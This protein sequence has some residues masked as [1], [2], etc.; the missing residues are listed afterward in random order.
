MYFGHFLPLLLT[1]CLILAGN[2]HI[3]GQ[4]KYKSISQDTFNLTDPVV[5][6]NVQLHNHND[7]STGQGVF[8]HSGNSNDS[9]D[10][11]PFAAGVGIDSLFYYDSSNH[12]FSDTAVI[13]VNPTI[14]YDTVYAA[15]T[16]DGPFNIRHAD[17]S[18]KVVGSFDSK[19][20]AYYGPGISTGTGQFDPG[21]GLAAGTYTIYAADTVTIDGSPFTDLDSTKVNLHD[22]PDVYNLEEDTSFCEGGP[23]VRLWLD[24]NQDGVHYV[25]E[26]AGTATPLDT[27][28]GDGIDTLAFHELSKEGTYQ[29][30]AYYDSIGCQTP[31]NGTVTVSEITA[32]S[33]NLEYLT[34]S[35]FCPGG[36]GVELGIDGSNSNYSYSLY[37]TVS[38]IPALERTEPG[39][40]SPVSLGTYSD[41]AG[42]YAVEVS[43]GTC[44]HSLDDTLKIFKKNSPEAYDLSGPAG[45]CP[46]A[47]SVQFDLSDSETGM[48]YDLINQNTGV[49]QDSVYGTGSAIHFTV[50]DTGTY[51]AMGIDTTTGCTNN[52]NNTVALALYPDVTANAWP[53]TAI[54]EGASVDLF[55][56]GAGTGGSY[57]WNPD[58]SMTGANTDNPTASPLSTTNYEV[59]FTDA[60]GCEAR[61]TVTVTVNNLPTAD[62]GTDTSVCV[63]DSVQLAAGQVSGATYSWSPDG[64][65]SSPDK[66][67][68]YA[69]PG[70]QTTYT[71]TV[72]SA[73][74][75]S[76]TDDVV[77][78]ADSVPSPSVKDEYVCQGESVT[79]TAGGGDSYYWP[80]E[81]TSGNSISVSPAS[82]ESYVVEAYY[83]NGCSANDTARVTVHPTPTINT[84][85]TDTSVCAQEDVTIQSSASGGNTPYTYSWTPGGGSGDNK[86]FTATSDETYKVTVTDQNGC[87]DSAFVPVTVNALPTVSISGLDGSYCKDE[88][89]DLITGA[90]TGSGGAF[91]PASV[92]SD[93]GDGTADFDPSS[94]SPDTY[95]DIT[96]SFTNTHGCEDTAMATTYV[97]NDTIPEPT[98]SGLD[99]AYCDDDTGPY[100]IT[101]HP[102]G[103]SGSFSSLTG[104]T[105]NGD[106]TATLDPQILADNLG[107]GS[108]DITYTYTSISGGCEGS[109]TETFQVGV[110]FTFDI[111]SDYCANQD[112]FR[113]QVNKPTNAGTG[114]FYVFDSAGDT[115][116]SAKEG[117]SNAIFDPASQGAGDYGVEY[118]VSDTVLSCS[119]EDSTGFTVHPVP[120]ARFTLD[121]IVNDSVDIQFCNNYGV[122]DLQGI[123]NSGG[124]YYGPG[125]SG[126][127]LETDSTLPG[128]IVI[129]RTYTSAEGCMDSVT[130]DVRIKDVPE[131]EI[132]GL[133]LD[134]CNNTDMF[135][136]TADPDSG[137]YTVPAPLSDPSIFK[138]KGQGKADFNPS[139]AAPGTYN[140]QYTGF[141][142][143]G[144]S[145]D[146]TVDVTIQPVPNVSVTGLPG[147]GEV[148]MNDS[149]IGVTGN[150]TDANGRFI[151]PSFINDHSDGTA[152]LDPSQASSS[153]SY[154]VIYEYVNSTSGCMARDT[155]II[156]ILPLPQTYNL[157]GGGTFCAGEAGLQLKLTDSDSSMLYSL[158]K[159]GSF[160]AD[161]LREQDGNFTFDGY[162]QEGTYLVTAEHAN[163]CLDTMSNTATITVKHAPED[164]YSITGDTVVATTST[165]SY[166]HDALDYTDQYN[167]E[168]PSGAV[169]TSGS[170]TRNIDV[171]FS[172]V[173]PGYD[174][175]LVYGT[176]SNSCGIGDTA[177]FKVEIV[178]LPDT[179][180]SLT[181][182]TG[183]CEGA[184]NLVYSVDPVGNADS[185]G[186]TIPTGFQVTTGAGTNSIEVDLQ[187]SASSGWVTARGYNASGSGYPDSLYVTVN[188]IP[189]ITVNNLDSVYCS[190]QGSFTIT[191]TPSGGIYSTPWSDPGIF[192]DNGD[193][194][195]DFNP[196]QLAGGTSHTIGYS[197]TVNGCKADTTM[198][199]RINAIPDV[200][201]T[202][203]PDTLC[204]NAAP[205][206]LEGNHK[207]SYASFTGPGIN[208]NND[209]TAFFYP[210]SA[211]TGDKTITYHYVD[212]LTGC[213]NDTSQDIFIKPAPQAYT[214]L[215]DGT[216]CADTPGDSLSLGGAQAGHLY[217][218]IRNGTTVAYDTTVASGGGFTFDTTFTQGS[219]EV[220]ATASNGCPDTMQNE[221]TI[222][223]K[224]LPDGAHSV[225]GDDTVQVDG[226]G[227]YSVPPIA[228]TADYHWIG[229]IVDS[230]NGTR[231]VK[232]DFSGLSPGDQT[233]G[234][235]GS[236]GCGHG[237]TAYYD[238]YVLP[239]PA[240]LDS[241]SGDSIVCAGSEGLVYQ[242]H[243]TLSEVDSISWSV[244]AGFDI[245]SG[246]GT[247][248]I[249]VH[250]D[251]TGA[252]SGNI[253]AQGV[254]ASGWGP[255]ESLYVT[256][257]PIPTTNSVS[258]TDV[259]DCNVNSVLLIGNSSTPGATYTWNGGGKTVH[260][261]SIYAPAKGDYTLTVDAYGCTHDTTITVQENKTTPSISTATPD[262]LTCNQPQVTLE[263]SSDA[264]NPYYIWTAGSGGHIVSGDSTA[265]PT[266]DSSATYT[267]Q[268][269]DSLNGCTNTATVKVEEDFTK[270]S[271][272][273]NDPLDIT[274][275][276][277]TSVVST[278]GLADASYHWSGPAGVI[279][280]G[281]NTAS[282]VVDKVGTYSLKVTKDDNGCSYTKSRTVGSDSTR[283]TI[284]SYT[285]S[286]D[287][288][289]SEPSVSLDADVPTSNV[290]Y[291]FD[292]VTSGA[293]ESTSGH[294]AHVEKEDHYALTV[295]KNNNGCSVTDTVFVENKQHTVNV[296]IDVAFATITCNKPTDT[297]IVT[298]D[299]TD[300]KV[301]WNA[302]SGGH[303]LSGHLSKQIIVDS[304]GRY[305]ATVTDTLTGCSNSEYADISKDLS[306]PHI[307]PITKSPDSITCVSDVNLK[308]DVIGYAS[309][310]WTGPGTISP[311]D[312]D[313]VYVSVPGQYTLT[314]TGSNGCTSSRSEDV[315]A[316]TASPDMALTTSYD[317]ITCNNPEE[318][319]E[320]ASSTPNVT[321]QWSRIAGSG[322][323]DNPN[324]QY[325]RVDGPGTYEVV[326]TADNGCITSG[327]VSVDTSYAQPVVNGFDSNPDSISCED[328]WVELTASSST[329]GADLLWTTT[330]TGDILNETTDTALVDAKGTYTLTV[331]HPTTGCTVDSTVDVYNNFAKPDAVVDQNVGQFT[332][333]TD[334]LQLDGTASTGV[335]F[336]W[337]TDN[338]HILTSN[339]VQQPLIGSDGK[340]ILTVEHP[341]SGCTDQ[342]S[343]VVTSNNSVP[344]I[345]MGPVSTD[346]LNCAVDSSVI[347]ISSVSTTEYWWTTP[348]GHIRRGDSSLTAVVD[349]PGK[350]VFTARNTTTGCTNSKSYNIY[351]ETT[352]PRVDLSAEKLTC[353]RDTAQISSYLEYATDLS[354]VSWSWITA[355]GQIVTAKNIPNPKVVKA[356]TYTLTLTDDVNGCTR[357]KDIDV[358]E[359]TTAPVVFVDNNVNDIT[360]SRDEV[361]LLANTNASDSSYE[362]ST[363]GT[364]NIVNRYTATPAVDAPGWYTVEITD[365][366]NGCS[367]EDSVYVDEDKG[368]PDLFVDPVKDISCSRSS[369][370]L[371]AG[372]SD[373]VYYSWSGGPGNISA[374]GSS[375]T[376]VDAGG[377]Y[378]ITLEDKVTGCTND[379]TITVYE[380]TDAPSAPMV[381]DTG[382]CYGSAN[383]AIDASGSVPGS[384][385][386][387]YD[388]PA[389]GAANQIATGSSYTP[390]MSSV[391]DSVFYVTQTGANGCESPAASAIYSV[392]GLPDAPAATDKS[393]CFGQANPFLEAYPTDP[394]NP[395]NWYNTSDSLL[396]TSD[397]YQPDPTT[398]GT[399]EY[400]V[401]QVD[402]RGCESP[403]EQAYFTIYDL[404]AAPVVDEDTL[405]ICEGAPDKTFV[406]HGTNVKWYNTMPPASEIAT[407]N[408]FTPG[409]S[410][411]GTYTFYVTQS[412]SS[413]GC[414]SYYTQVTY[415]I[416]AN[417]DPYAVQGGGTYCEG[418]GGKEIFLGNSN[419]TVSYELRQD[420]NTYLTNISG[421][422]DSLSFGHI[423]PEGTYT[424]YGTATNG[425]T[426]K[427]TGTAVI[428]VDSLP[429][430]AGTITGD[431]VLCQGATGVDYSVPEISYA[432]Q[433]E[434]TIPEGAEI[435]AGDK[436]PTITVN[437]SDTAQS[438]MITVY[439]SNGC[440]DGAVSTGHAITVN[441]VPKAAGT[442]S[443]A[444]TICQGAEAVN[445]E[446]A[447][448]EDASE[449]VWSVPAGATIVSGAGSRSIL[450]SFD[451]SATGGMVKVYGR[452]NCGAGP[453][454]PDHTIS[455]TPK[456][457]ITTDTYK[458]ICASSDSLI[459]D[460]PG[461]ADIQWR[462]IDGQAAIAS[463]NSFETE[464]T[465]LGTGP[466]A[467]EVILTSN[468][469]SDV[470]TV[471]IENNQRFVNA[472]ADQTLC[473]AS[474]T[475]SGS[476][477]GSDVI[478]NWSV[479]QGSA[480]FTDAGQYNTTVT[481]LQKGVNV[482]RWTLSKDGCASYD[483]VTII[484]DSPTQAEAGIDQ[485]LCSDSTRLDANSPSTGGGEWT[486]LEGY[487]DFQ[488]NTDPNTKIQNVAKGENLLRWTITN[489]TCTSADTVRITNNQVSVEAGPDQVIC[490]YHTMLNAQTPAKGTGEWSIISGSA[491]FSDRFDPNS[492]VYLLISDTTVLAWNVYH[493]GCQSADSMTIINN[494]PS[495]AD[496]GDN[497]EIFQSSTFLGATPPDKGTGQWSL[498]SGSAVI[499]DKS[500]PKTEVTELAYGGS[501]FQWKVTYEN[502][503]SIDSVLIDNQSSGSIDAGADTIICS[504]AMRLNASEPV[505]GEGEW[506]VVKG[507]GTFDNKN[508]NTTMV[509]NLSRGENIL[510]WTII[511]NGIISDKITITNNAPTQPNAGPDMSYCVDSVQLS[512]NNPAVGTGVWRLIAGEGTF[513]DSTKNNTHIED[514][515]SGK[516]TLRWTITNKNCTSTDDVVITNNQPTRADA[517]VDQTL[518]SDEASLYGNSPSV[519]EGLWTLVSGSN[520]VAF[521]DQNVGNTRV[522]N[523]GHGDNVLRWTIT[524]GNCVSSD[525]VVITNDNPTKAN[526]GRDKSICV[527]SFKLNANEAV[528]GNGSW[529]VI[530]GYGDFEDSSD[531]GTMVKNLDK[532]GN[533]LRWSIEH[534]G[535]ISYDEVEISNDL[536]EADAGYDQS[537]CVDSTILSANNA[538]KGEGYW[539][540]VTG[541]AVFEDASNPNT[542]V[543]S[544]DYRSD[545]ILK[546]TITHKSCMSTDQIT[547]ENNSP[548]IVF[549]GEDDQ[550]CD[551]A[552]YLKA[553]PNYMGD[554][555]WE[556]ISG[557]ATIVKDSSAS[558]LVRDMGLGRNTFRWSVRRNGC[559][560]HDD[561]TI[562][563]NLPVQA[564]AGEDDTS[565]TTSYTLH[566][567]EP[568]FGRGQWTV[569]AGSGNFDEDTV[570]NTTVSNLSQGANT[571]KWTVYNG[572]CSTTDE[573]TIVVNRPNIPRAGAD[574]EICA[575]STTLQANLPG[576]GQ[577]GHWEVV[578]GSGSFE[579]PGDPNSKVTQMSYGTNVFRWNISYKSCNLYDEVTITNN[580]PT[581]AN[582]GQDIHVCGDQVRLNAVSTSIGA[583][584]WSLVSGQ[585]DFDDK[586]DASTLVSNLGFGSNTLR[587]KTTHGNC[588]SLDDINVYNDR[589]SAYAGVDQEVYRDSTTLVA[590]SVTRGEGEWI[591]LGGSGTFAS[592][593]ASQTLVRDLSPGVNTFRWTIN[594][595]GCIS[596][597]EV[598]ITYY[599]MPDPEFD[600]DSDHGCPPL[601][602]QFYNESLKVNSNF[603]WQFGDG[604]TS[605]NENPRHTYYQPGE[606]EVN[607]KTQGPDG[608]TVT[609]DT[610]I[611][612]HDLPEA[613]FDV[614][615]EVLYIP[616]QHLQC[617][618]MS[619]DA[620]R[621]KWHFGDDSISTEPSPMHH[622]RD[623]GTYDIRLEVWS[624][625]NC[626]DDT[627]RHDLVT[628][629]Q[630][631]K[632]RFPSGFTPNP[633]GPVGGHYN[634]NSRDNDVFH[635]IV[636][637]VDEYHMEIFNRWGVKVFS[638]DK[639]EVGWDGYYQGKPAEEGVYIYKV[640]GTYNNGTRFE[641]V[642]DF[643]LIRK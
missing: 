634:V 299:L 537:L 392:Y 346:T 624:R 422:G 546:W 402:A 261:D 143:E 594:N 615:P 26:D 88:P 9:Y 452:N 46:D 339:T 209:G 445:F 139:N 395:I 376:E 578:E 514:M 283:P 215:A 99:S 518:C 18:S 204:S 565:C 353:A 460:D 286:G 453:A 364:G 194:T 311:D 504:D 587:W 416:Q 89:V 560:K 255:A 493:N 507:S 397:Q 305:T 106:G 33:P 224:E 258:V 489:N 321:Y 505:Q 212:S 109:V 358:T 448:I 382:S 633:H 419:A 95:Y 450:V 393:I 65:L 354:K 6:D 529:S 579:D 279:A 44:T 3:F 14:N 455:V 171:S 351:K 12:V 523:L 252:S 533:V 610:I 380:D 247:H 412:G 350:Y 510:K 400:G 359:N 598:S 20:V 291:E 471:V 324:S 285:K 404:P 213:S 262:T 519:G 430:A 10:Y 331:T 437:Y 227:R 145:A 373:D 83:T 371:Q 626:Y 55:A 246:R 49:R 625:Y 53:D 79:L 472:G 327:Q 315:P 556:A 142:D 631:G 270:P 126:D 435:V 318:K 306:T 160:A 271:F 159:D 407:G 92:V 555:K 232:M 638:S 398:P 148:C 151:S 572:R 606:Y 326:V 320:V 24:G 571:F 421:D 265:T 158:Y 438:G 237:D 43:N 406:A 174:S 240:A 303:I 220:V 580:M 588:T 456:P 153:G 517:G 7:T 564:Y 138:D 243:P 116:Y 491:T 130:A 478:G 465:G 643:V 619:I 102:T 108:Y 333:M 127:K 97:S 335:N 480:S 608:T 115:L 466:N 330:G 641:K 417:P 542:D 429:E 257:N 366:N 568:P 28:T 203:L 136:I 166:S 360:C 618:D 111:N 498:L 278:P 639:V 295:T 603:T 369:V 189:D 135:E 163:G 37:H 168:V 67:K 225:S 592:P 119:N 72:T 584:R 259:L 632:I 531:Q 263:A 436:S 613:D 91:S 621:Y 558:T 297:L 161:T 137:F 2:G 178:A 611:T 637:G 222:H 302:S 544:L 535:C 375:L 254:N 405:R 217:E 23:G 365:N 260:N 41:S 627:V 229:A 162:W 185:V 411:V 93:N 457:I 202:G 600:V 223:R 176:N 462:L 500:D 13:V 221:V 80:S 30:Y 447:A 141:G 77:V 442:I 149:P 94:V 276:R 561:V 449:Y 207:N 509:R 112:S 73:Q 532:G 8:N 349:A 191:S 199:V 22:P 230:G 51:Y 441:A 275:S 236:N 388:A 543:K 308:T 251:S 336:F 356:G 414:E 231:R 591:I 87:R 329:T 338:G 534:N 216:Y 272:T 68:T 39:T 96:Y 444:N 290:T 467:F 294:I 476:K 409:A 599:E 427:M 70:T 567:E 256:V 219:Y 47:P 370:E 506:S 372:S 296:T 125:V 131:L 156:D 61:D 622:Y 439:G 211:G 536:I 553:N 496:A 602:V 548:G 474:Y 384:N 387:W 293:I 172:G 253:T 550:V 57:Q 146:T 245:I 378:T 32:T 122:V 394:A 547:V 390:S 205:V 490:G 15:C 188:D 322:N 423:N 164:A 328:G 605:V 443:G 589:A 304:A 479:E 187:P 301:Q 499:A 520:S 508:S 403:Q 76:N 595:N 307:D 45:L 573:V 319:L 582:A 495:R 183:L 459:A 362:W 288:T 100:T 426:S 431:S 206:K 48:R 169:I 269:T 170:G 310:Q 238:V 488:S 557:G 620:D 334:T 226:I 180:R 25:L 210:D 280:S 521:Q 198:E 383:V 128:D 235:Y 440:G 348:D 470:D 512:A 559:V 266:V 617:Y 90:P 566:A 104:L 596:S 150:P 492:E 300:K 418:T 525:E 274:C 40:G 340:Y 607:L 389:L 361:D 267:V 74:G 182:K 17:T 522:T 463:P 325:P 451:E 196:S 58:S 484:N 78:D 233:V 432:D 110:P 590:N 101:G 118:V 69:G 415:I 132:H 486:V 60:N 123:H 289:C 197:A 355:G 585:A 63:G 341:H 586:T 475:L 433:Y 190:D 292:P 524:N 173:T 425:C 5:I 483:E 273:M 264:G 147:S 574:Q 167:W 152:T 401:T 642:G 528:V 577:S 399:Y 413:T 312:Q 485:Q 234:V 513:T 381:S 540:V 287:I 313:S 385:F 50:T 186:W 345:T 538:G 541:S 551:D 66:R 38:G 391:G 434:W 583:G 298:S 614:A 64:T 386:T 640:H 277:D 281:Q 623:T 11:D 19:K 516:N 377:N 347:Q 129:S 569:V 464:V 82:D 54:C 181:G 374:P 593:D 539:S 71:V 363:T 21:G 469:C 317:D 575:D 105:D 323:L 314:A 35:A 120:D 193:G 175:I 201:F 501:L 42:Y 527:D 408:I 503:V 242:A 284:N 157:Q 154:Q 379:S 249:H 239:E 636:K 343:V 282:I 420:G 81:G 628:V 530:N 461:S 357:V 208:D 155:Q 511:G 179:A 344:D 244:P 526:A 552:Y 124:S 27:V 337:T 75:C 144:C 4:D 616:E 368:T 367:A 268:V 481:N 396:S 563:N 248:S 332:C 214:L 570:F 309:L 1:G 635:P 477:P 316:D 630:S 629:E 29:A 98:I 165:G 487:V 468:G 458:A 134:T 52:M 428:S 184:Q 117:S 554:G 113:L 545:N 107:T 31:M 140:I 200:N 352:K 133:P 114:T 342:D 494:S 515:G 85:P 250:V 16:S 218:V 36:P 241:V 62:A 121:G 482:L 424:V 195:A 612:V 604:N 177:F 86:T 228:N 562:Y 454:S 34:D 410:G 103:S 502:C 581:R 192:A 497:Q 473:S 576:P 56:S 601:S 446:V 59:V 549:A 609:E 84:T 597:D